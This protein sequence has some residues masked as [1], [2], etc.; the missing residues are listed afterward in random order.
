[1]NSLL[2]EHDDDDDEEGGLQEG[3]RDVNKDIAE[4]AI[5]SSLD[6]EDEKEEDEV[7]LM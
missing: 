6:A 5:K 7:C 3:P 2:F 1:M 4:W